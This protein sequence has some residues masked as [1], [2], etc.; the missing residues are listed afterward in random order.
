MITM[1][2]K[3]TADSTS[4]KVF[5][6]DYMGEKGKDI[7]ASSHVDA[8][9]QYAAWYGGRCDDML[10]KTIII[11]VEKEGVVQCFRLRAELIIQYSAEIIE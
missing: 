6:E 8:A 10:T 4:Y 7:I 9:L 1:T 2:V 5:H 3:N 11:K